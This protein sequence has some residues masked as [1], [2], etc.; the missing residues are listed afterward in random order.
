VCFLVVEAA[1]TSN[2]NLRQSSLQTTDTRAFLSF[3]WYPSCHRH[4]HGHKAR[5]MPSE[6]SNLR[7]ALVRILRARGVPHADT[8]VQVIGVPQE[9][10]VLFT[11]KAEER[12]GLAVA[13]ALAS[14]LVKTFYSRPAE[15]VLS[16]QEAEAVI[17]AT[18]F[19]A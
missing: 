12:A 11:V 14:I 6:Q 16:E 10:P 2:T 1:H 4:R 5:T 17:R 7:G 18:R 3:P 9:H 15:W 13:Q 19:G 8:A